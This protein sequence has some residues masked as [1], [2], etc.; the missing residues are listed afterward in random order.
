MKIIPAKVHIPTFIYT[1][2]WLSY[3][4]LDMRFNVEI[5]DIV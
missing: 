2:N 3:F 4:L 1:S 5:R